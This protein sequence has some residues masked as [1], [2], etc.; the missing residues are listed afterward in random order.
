MLG[1]A[2]ALDTIHPQE[3]TTRVHLDV[4]VLRR[5]PDPNLSKIEPNQTTDNANH[6]HHHP[7]A[8]NRLHCHRDMIICHKNPIIRRAKQSPG[9][10]SPGSGGEAEAAEGE[11]GSGEDPAVA[12]AVVVP[13]P[14]GRSIPRREPAAHLKHP[15]PGG[16]RG[17][18]P[19]EEDGDE[20]EGSS[21]QCRRQG[22]GS[23][24]IHCHR[25]DEDSP[26]HLSLVPS[27]LPSLP[28]PLRRRE[29][30]RS[31]ESKKAVRGRQR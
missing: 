21:R 17:G 22:G 23:S 8:G 26:S 18:G 20:E 4:V 12:V 15:A 28:C 25:A 14:P 27:F 29:Q 30:A 6:H 11:V 2:T 31:Y 3:V 5:R 13:E 1:A 7:T 16:G 24:P 9:V 19:K 10:L